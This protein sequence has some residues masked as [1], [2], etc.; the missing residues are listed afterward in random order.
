MHAIHAIK[1]KTEQN[2]NASRRSPFTRNTIILLS[3]FLIGLACADV[4]AAGIVTYVY[5]A[6]V[7]GIAGYLSWEQLARMRRQK[8]VQQHI[9]RSSQ[10]LERRIDRHI[11]Q[12]PH[13]RNRQDSPL[14]QRHS[15]Q[16]HLSLPHSAR[17]PRR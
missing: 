8:A 16:Q 10:T 15:E 6:G 7:F 11:S 5:A 9:D 14:H 2:H 3:G 13:L 17:R 4:I 1:K 12:Q